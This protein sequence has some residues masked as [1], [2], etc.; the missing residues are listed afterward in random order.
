MITGLGFGLEYTGIGLE[1]AVLELIP[2][3]AF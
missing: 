3:E 2:V 1:D